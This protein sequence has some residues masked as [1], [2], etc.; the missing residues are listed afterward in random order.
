MTTS[1]DIT[2]NL[3]DILSSLPFDQQ[4]LQLRKKYLALDEQDAQLLRSLNLSEQVQQTLMDRFYEHLAQFPQTQSLFDPPIMEKLQTRQAE[5]F[6]RLI[7]GEYDWEYTQNRLRIGAVHQQVGLDTPWY[8][9]AYCKYLTNII[10]ELFNACGEDQ[11]LTTDTLIALLKVTFL[12]ISLAIDT[13]IHADNR[14]I[15]S[16]KEYAE[17][18]I[19]TVPLGLL[20]LDKKHNVLS[21]NS[22]MDRFFREDHDLLRGRN[23]RDLFTNTDLKGR[24]SEVMS[25]NRAQSGIAVQH[26]DRHKKVLQ[27]QVTLVPMLSETNV[28]T[29]NDAPRV[30]VVIEDITEKQNLINATVSADAHI[31]SIM[32]NVSD[33]IITIDPYGRIE[34]FN[35]SAEQLFQ[36]QAAEIIGQNIKILMP[37]PYYSQHD[38]YLKRYQVKGEAHCVGN[39]FQ[40][41]EGKRQDGSVFPMDLAISEMKFGNKTLYIGLVRDISERIKTEEEMMKLSSAVEQTADAVII[42]DRGGTIEYVNRGFEQTTGYK[43]NEVMGRS[44][45]ILKSGLLEPE[46]YTALWN[47]ISDAKT[48]RGIFINKRKDGTPYYEEKTITPLMDTDKKITHFV[49]TG[50]D[51]SKRMQDQQRLDFLA[52]H[53]ILTSLPNRLLFSDRLN[54]AISHAKRRNHI[55]ALMFMDLDRFKNINDTLGHSVGDA[56]LK[57]IAKRLKQLLRN[58]D[59]VARISGDE[60]AILLTNLESVDGIP[61][62]ATKLLR[63]ISKPFSIAGR[64]LFITSSIGITTYPMDSADPNTLLKNADT[65]MY[66][67][68]NSGRDNYCFYTSTM[69]AM[70]ERQFTLETQLRRALERGEFNL[71]YQP[72]FNIKNTPRRSGTEALLRWRNPD[73]G[74]LE[75]KEFLHLVEDS[76]MIQP[77]GE[78]V[79]HTACMQQRLWLDAKINSNYI[80]VNVSPKQLTKGNFFETV[81]GILKDTG[82]P[83]E[84][85]YLEITENALMENDPYIIDTLKELT[86]IGVRIA[87]DDFGT[88]YSSLSHVRH[89]PIS[90]LKIDQS[91]VSHIPDQRDDTELART[92]ITL[93]KNLN[94]DVIAEG[95]ET[96]QQLDALRQM[97][98]VNVQ[99]FYF[100]QPQ[101]AH[102]LTKA[103]STA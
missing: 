32:D 7:S 81:G 44:P 43:R 10:P 25:S 98:C 22:F 69:N 53:D 48:F 79:L 71:F 58:E 60:F 18:I 82:L 23:I 11:K 92:I 1:E 100:S 80:A 97:G 8:I 49:S 85:L 36:Y 29:S 78:W 89:F 99:G 42:T 34:S 27:L 64:E 26:P 4:S 90:C 102:N 86:E 62:I 83:P 47:T 15:T 55:V 73:E 45:R 9:G 68:K 76:S 3:E 2:K 67:A 12:D 88:G 17:R 95:V 72:Q 70:A 56:L 52:H 63:S 51:I 33:G 61:L 74:Y 66:Q 101:D 6:K 96:K 91:F 59:T 65:A 21:V 28:I 40:V 93:G 39:E 103:V 46:F 35:T 75:P 19:C 14:I 54:Q 84:Q 16:L 38:N 5:Y 20:V 57:G 24:I 50:K 41:M 31:R 87:L 13:Y 94:L 37:E 30:L 77:V